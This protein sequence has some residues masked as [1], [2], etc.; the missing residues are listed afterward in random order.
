MFEDIEDQELMELIK[1]E[2][3]DAFNEL[4]S[5]Y[6]R[7]V[8]NLAYKWTRN[9]NEAE[10]VTQ[11]VFEKIWVRKNTY[12]MKKSKVSSWIYKICQNTAFDFLRRKKKTS[13]LDESQLD[14]LVDDNINL[15]NEIEMHAIRQLL[16]NA[17]ADL[18]KEQ[19]EIIKLMYFEGKT[20]KEIAASLNI[21][22]G[23]VKS[24]VKLAMTKLRRKIKR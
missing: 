10:E 1:N 22:L 17:I 4:Y 24:R 19:Q 12:V 9:I 21:P 2:N 11:E 15:E 23:T 14:F 3:L 5:R 6:G 16:R 18:P 7:L 8:F 13:Y 20:Q